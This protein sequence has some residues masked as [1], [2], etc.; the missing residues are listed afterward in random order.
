MKKALFAVLL[1]YMVLAGG[2]DFPSREPTLDVW[3]GFQN[4]PPGYGEVPFWWWTGEDLDVKRLIGQVDQLHAMG[5]SGVQ[6]NYSHHDTPGW[7]TDQDAPELFSDAWWAIY[8]EVSEACA[9]RNMGIGLSTYTLDWPNG[10]TNLF[11]RL[12]YQHA[13]WHA[14]SL[15]KAFS[16]RLDAQASLRKELPEDCLYVC[17]YRVI[18]GRPAQKA[19]DLTPWIKGRILT[20]QAPAD[21]AYDVL[22]VRCVRKDGSFNPM[23]KDAGHIIVNGF[24]QPFEDHAQRGS[25][26]GLNYFFNDELQIGAGAMAWCEDFAEQFK[27]RKGYALVDVLPAL[28]GD[29]GSIT[30]KARIDY[31]D[32]RMS[33]MEERYFQ[34]IYDWHAQRKIIFGCDPCSRGRNPAEFGDYFRANRWYT[35]PGHDTP[36]GQ[37]D[38]IKNKVS[39]SI[40][41]LYN[42]PRVWLEG[43]HSLGWGATLEQLMFA[44]RENYLYG[45]TLLNLHGLYY[46]TYG[47]YWEWAPPCYHFRMPYWK[48]MKAF[49]QY[50]ERLSYVLSQGTFVCDVGIVYPVTPYEAGFDGDLAKRTAFDLGEKLFRAGINFEFVDHQSLTR[51]MPYRV[52]LYPAMQAVR[53][54]GVQGSCRFAEAGGKVLCVGEVPRASDR[55]GAQDATLDDTLKQLFTAVCPTVDA[56]VSA[57]QQTLSLPDVQGVDGAVRALHRRVGLRDIYLVMDAKPGDHVL[58][59]ATGRVESWDPWTGKAMPLHAEQVSNNQMRVTLTAQPYEASLVVFTPGTHVNPS[60]EETRPWGKKTLASTAWS[61]AFE[62]TMDNRYGDFRLPVEPWN[63]TIGVEARRVAWSRDQKHWTTQLLGYGPQFLVSSQPTNSVAG[64][65]AATAEYAFSW[66]YGKEGDPG[67]Q[68]YHG[69]KRKISDDFIC[70]GKTKSGLNETLYEPDGKIY[71]LTSAVTLPVACE[72]EILCNLNA[73]QIEINGNTVTQ[74]CVA[75]KA[76]VNPIRVTCLGGRGHVV[77]RKTSGG[78]AV[79]KTPLAMRWYDDPSVIPFDVS[80]GDLRPEYFRLT[81]APGTCALYLPRVEGSVEIWL[82]G[83]PMKASGNNRFV[84]AVPSLKAGEVLLKVTPRAPGYSGGNLI[85][86]PICVE[87]SGQGLMALGD[88]SKIGVLNNYSGGVRYR[89]CVVLTAEETQAHALRLDLGNVAG[90]AEVWINQKPV[91]V[92]VAPPWQ[93]DIASVVKA[94]TNTIEV[95]VLN[96]L[97]NHYQ[98]TPSKYKGNPLSGLLGPVTLQGQGWTADAST[99]I[100]TS[101]S[102]DARVRFETVNFSQDLARIAV[103]GVAFTVTGTQQHAGGGKDFSAL[104]NGSALNGSG[105][106]QTRDDGQTFVGFG[107]GNQLTVRLNQPQALHEVITYAG[108]SDGR[109]SQNYDVWVATQ[110]APEKF[111]LLTHVTGDAKGGFSRATIRNRDGTA[112][113]ASIVALQ[114]QFQDGPQG[115]NVYR[116]ISWK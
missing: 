91:G 57:V 56:A 93:F 63:Q 116:E 20:W 2:D 108:H 99:R 74:S 109:A 102:M 23:F 53:W 28:F 87:T 114:F 42:R 70:L 65:A 84:A 67:H 19:L 52:L 4:P 98:T 85:P 101:N 59:R 49:L 89:T 80:A 41:N 10:S 7:M 58:F 62:P 90:T 36:G 72:A 50:F 6:V 86:E 16:M 115:F 96:T 97:A 61:V 88:W 14:R 76:G 12:F 68:G 39:S 22:G 107:S 78:V 35:A 44:T 47:S 31:A 71:T 34:P 24:Y 73:A 3:P 37:A 18:A 21:G 106:E 105:G 75:L 69:L 112:L 27:Q 81:S 30:S 38:L 54:A 46:S 43:Y 100:Q 103:P 17:A 29:Q 77:V 83:V 95:L 64:P 94:G 110:D 32:V 60:A 45:A 1:P 40:A 113:G 82:D 104:F 48:H 5:I 11:Q 25:S 15:E 51:P 33:L 92:R 111:A 79:R 8:T 9:A 66:R 55:A 13:P 26:K